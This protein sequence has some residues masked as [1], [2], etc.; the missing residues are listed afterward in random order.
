MEKPDDSELAGLVETAMWHLL[1][2]E[3]SCNFF[4]GE[5]WV[6]RSTAD[7]DVARDALAE[8][9]RRLGPATAA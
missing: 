6:P 9:E 5:A 7:L 4:W 8:I 3:T 1:R 2:G